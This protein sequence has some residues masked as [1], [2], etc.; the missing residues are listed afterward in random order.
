MMLLGEAYAS[1][2]QGPLALRK[3]EGIKENR[4]GHGGFDVSHNRGGSVC[5]EDAE[6]RS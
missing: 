2:E 3:E 1:M 4:P 5:G 6:P